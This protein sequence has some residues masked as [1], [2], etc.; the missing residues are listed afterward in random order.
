VSLDLATSLLGWFAANRRQLPWRLPFPRDPYRVL[1]AEVMSQQTQLERITDRFEAFLA[2][3]PT[4]EALAAA[5]EDEVVEAFSGLGYYRRARLLQRAAR[6]VAA[7]GGWPKSAA[8]LAGLPGLGPYTSAALAAFCFAGSEPPVD[9]N[10][11]RV[12]ARLHGLDLP[13][14]SNRLLAHA[15][16][17]AAELRSRAATPAVFEALMEL[18]ATVCTPRAPRCPV[19][20]WRASCVAAR[21]GEV[22]R[23]PGIR[24]RRASERHSWAVV[25]LTDAAGRVLLKRVVEGPL[26]AGLWLPPFTALGPGDDPAAVAADLAASASRAARLVP[27]PPIRHSI[28]HRRIRVFPFA[29]YAPPR[30]G[31]A[32][33]DEAFAD[34]L[35]PGLPTSTLLAKLHRVCRA[36]VPG[37]SA[38]AVGDAVT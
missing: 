8:Q 12:A 18:G 4:A 24:P 36:P 31:E 19:C 22:E 21:A 20:P 33:P 26:L 32:S 14:G 28:T 29:G 30:A 23:Y 27:R 35:A 7:R 25:W 9:G 34:P 5:A 6:A 2:R 1:V 37:A 16:T 15:R 10:V 3:F 17:L 38:G 13:M 11:A